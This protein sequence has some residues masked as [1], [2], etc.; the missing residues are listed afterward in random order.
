MLSLTGMTLEVETHDDSFFFFLFF[1]SLWKRHVTDT[2]EEK[3]IIEKSQIHS[4]TRGDKT[5]VWR[6]PEGSEDIRCERTST[7]SMQ[8]IP[9]T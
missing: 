4:L 9:D 6:V 7:Y 8:V 5:A 3:E 1:L 2:R